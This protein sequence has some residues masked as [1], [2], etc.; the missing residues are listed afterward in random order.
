M[1]A[2]QFEEAKNLRDDEF[3][4]CCELNPE[5][6]VEYYSWVDSRAAT[7]NG[8]RADPNRALKPAIAINV[9]TR[10]PIVR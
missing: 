7:L 8:L 10:R 2:E 9:T 6:E 1:T 3:A 5:F 4:A